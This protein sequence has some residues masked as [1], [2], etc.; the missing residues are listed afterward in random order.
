LFIAG[1][2]FA[3]FVAIPVALRFLLSFSTATIVPMITVKNYIAFVGTMLLAFGI[4]FELPLVIM[5][6]TR[7]G[8]AT[9]KFLAEKRRHAIVLIL[10]VSAILTP[11]D[12]FTQ[13][14]VALPLMILYEIGLLASKMAFSGKK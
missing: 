8:I 11:P 4:I 10:I 2:L 12:C 14:L 6:L 7:I 3:Y 5:F 13:A 9:P 1:G